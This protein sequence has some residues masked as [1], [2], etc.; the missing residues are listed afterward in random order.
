MRLDID[1]NLGIGE[2]NPSY[3]LPAK[4]GNSYGYNNSVESYDNLN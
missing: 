1:G 2:T 3:K 4:R